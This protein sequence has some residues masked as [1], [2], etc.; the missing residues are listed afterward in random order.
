MSPPP[1]PSQ[2]PRP[3][4]GMPPSFEHVPVARRTD[5]SLWTLDGQHRHAGAGT[6]GDVPFLP[7][8]ILAARD[9]AEAARTFVDPNTR[10][11]RFTQGEV[12]VCRLAAGDAVA[13]RVQQLPDAT[14]WKTRQPRPGACNLRQL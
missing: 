6:R 10:R 2:Q 14:G 12:F 3:Q 9:V 4:I 8:V 5:G 1:K 7:C 11:Q 13:V